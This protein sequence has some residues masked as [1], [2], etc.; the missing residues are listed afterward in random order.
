MGYDIGKMEIRKFSESGIDFQVEHPMDGPIFDDK[1]KALTINLSGADSS[2]I[3]A[4]VRERQKKQQAQVEE[5]K[6]PI[7][8][9]DQMREDENIED[10]VTLTNGW[11][12]NWELDGQPFPFSKDNAAKLYRRFPDIAAWATSKVTTRINFMQGWSKK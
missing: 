10:L 11:S 8:Y 4:A 1:K 5:T 2:R 9:D 7:E 3:K 6:K 12:D